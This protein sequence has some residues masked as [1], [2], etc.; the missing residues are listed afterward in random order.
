[1][2]CA[3]RNCSP[4][5][6]PASDVANFLAELYEEGYQAS[7]LNSFRSAISSVHDQID[8]FTIGKHPMICRVLKGAFNVRPPVPCYTSTWNIQTVLQYLESIG[9]SA[10]LSLKPLTF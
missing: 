4:I 7:S 1:V 2:W 9:P 6:G 10:S 3:E 5:S 8:G